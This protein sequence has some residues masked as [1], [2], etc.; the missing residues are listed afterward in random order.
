MAALVRLLRAAPGTPESIGEAVRGAD[1]ARLVEDSARHG[2]AG[3]VRQVL[4]GAGVAVS[5]PEHEALQRHALAVAAAGAR[6]KR[7]LL[8]ALDALKAQGLTPVLLKGYGLALRLYPDPLLRASTDV[9][10]WVEPSELPR[11]E[12]ALRGLGL[13]GGKEDLEDPALH[14]RT[15]AGKAGVVELH[16]RPLSSF[17]TP[18][19]GE[20]LR[21]H[22]VEAEVE[23]RAVRYLAPED[24]LAY[25]AVHATH[26]MLQR[27]SWL[28]D[29]K[30]YVAKYPALDWDGVARAAREGG[31]AGLAFFALEAARRALG[32]KVPE[33]TLA[34]LRPSRWQEALARRLFSDE[35][36]ATAYLARHKS[37]WYVAK[38]LLAQ[39]VAGPARLGLSRLLSAA[40]RRR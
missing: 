35:R 27:L 13:S 31:H 38:G 26:H 7:L 10:L 34:A 4:E 17:G 1:W 40:R 18:L 16:Y 39:D 3:V 11:A 5:A 14:H 30:L 21:A 22:S 20:A 19:E 9:D 8:Q 36:L 12:V 6:M 24:E 28:Y 15:F 37:A 32:A 23:G 33:A 2:V 29:L 25:L